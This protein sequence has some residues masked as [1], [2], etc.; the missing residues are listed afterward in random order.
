MPPP[1]EDPVDRQIRAWFESPLY[2][3]MYAHRNISEARQFLRSIERALDLRPP[4]V[5]VDAGCGSGRLTFLLAQKGYTVLAVDRSREMIRRA[6]NRLASRPM[7]LARVQFFH[8][9]FRYPICRCCAD[10]IISLFSSFGYDPDPGEDQCI[11]KAFS[12]MV[13]SAGWLA[14]DYANPDYVRR[15]LVPE[16]TRL[17]R[18]NSRVYRVRIHRWIDPPFVM[19]R[20]IF[21]LE[22]SRN[23]TSSERYEFMERLRLY[24]REELETLLN[25]AGFQVQLLW[26]NYDASPWE[27]VRSPRMIFLCRKND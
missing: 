12:V 22:H 23:P 6:R 17:L 26:G 16:E 8:Q 27:G 9:D 7:L 15:H 10:G 19:K 24:S 13:K 25:R 18:E 14:L 5:V 4:A 21:H 1:R 20:M 3:A 2:D 11:L